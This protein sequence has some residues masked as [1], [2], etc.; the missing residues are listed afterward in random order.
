MK[1]TNKIDTAEADLEKEAARRRRLRDLLKFEGKMLWE[2]DLDDLRERRPRG[3]EI[4][5]PENSTAGT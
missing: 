1:P 3:R 2:G 4:C 5:A